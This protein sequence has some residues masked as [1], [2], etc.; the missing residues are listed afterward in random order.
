MIIAIIGVLLHELI[1]LDLQPKF[2][3]NRR[4]GFGSTI[5]VILASVGSWGHAAVMAFS[6]MSGPRGAATYHSY[7]LPTIGTLEL[8]YIGPVDRDVYVDPDPGM[9]EEEAKKVLRSLSEAKMRD[10]AVV[11]L[12]VTIGIGLLLNPLATFMTAVMVAA[13]FATPPPHDEYAPGQAVG[14][15]DGIYRIEEDLILFRATKGVAYVEDGCVMSRLHVTGGRPLSIDGESI[16]PCYV[17]HT[18]DFIAWGSQPRVEPLQSDDEVVAMILHPT[19]DIVVPTYSRCAVIGGESVCKLIRTAPGTSGSPLFVVREIE[20]RR[21]LLY[22]GAVGKNI[23]KDL[24]YQ[25][26]IQSHMPVRTYPNETAISPGMTLQLFSHPGSGK[27]R[28]LM[29]YVGQ[30]LAYSDMVV[31]AGPTRVVARELLDSLKGVPSVGCWIKG[32]THASRDCRIVV[33]THQTLLR[34]LITTKLARQK[35]VSYIVDETHFDQSGTKLLLSMLRKRQEAGGR[36]A[37]LEMTATGYDEAKEEYSVDRGSNYKIVDLT[38]DNVVAAAEEYMKNN[39]NHRVGVFVPKMIGKGV[40]A[41]SVVERYRKQDLNQKV[42]LMARSTYSRASNILA[43]EIG[44]V[45]I[46]TTSISECGANYDLDAVFD[47]CRQ[48]RY[49]CTPQGVKAIEGPITQAQIIQRRGRVGRRREGTYVIPTRVHTETLEI[50]QPKDSATTFEAMA[51]RR[52]FEMLDERPEGQV[53]RMLERINVTK[54]QVEKWITSDRDATLLETY[55]MY[56]GAGSRRSAGAVVAT[57]KWMKANGLWDDRIEMAQHVVDR[58]PEV[59]QGS[60]EM[61]IDDMPQA[62]YRNTGYRRTREK[63]LVVNSSWKGKDYIPVALADRID[64]LLRVREDEF[65]ASED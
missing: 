41:L 54:E 47:T 28:G 29:E 52:A 8:K 22:T 11:A 7:G 2:S 20:G 15:R 42:I 56:D 65:P 50:L 46:V 63:A 9:S 13:T 55:M 26:E 44:P 12:L 19:E 3:Y 35:S 31:I 61:E 37:L 25:Y 40:S 21:T 33:T 45:C 59:E 53:A 18:H 27:T 34:R 23:Q 32:R 6:L 4:F 57:S 64:K 14:L 51:A 58:L 60:W 10:V 49:V 16:G 1:I 38:A 17:S 5:R 30:M 62:V 48:N 43:T 36:G 24:R 39:P